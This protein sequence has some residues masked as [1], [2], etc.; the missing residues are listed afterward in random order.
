MRLFLPLLFFVAA[1][2]ALAQAPVVDTAGTGRLID[3][4]MNHSEVMQNLQHLSDV[5]GPRLSGSPAMRR[6][7][8]WSAERVRGD[9]LTAALEPYQF[10]VTWERGPA[11]LRLTAPFTRQVTA[12]SWAWTEGT[13]GKTLSG[14]VVMT[15]LSTPESLA[16]YK[17]KVK[18]A[19]VLPR[20]PFPIWNPDGPPMTAADSADL[21]AQ[22]KLRQS[23]FA[24]PSA[25]AVAA[26]RQFQI[27]LP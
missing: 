1:G 26:R 17:D 21:Q 23:P 9:G 15:D 19:W 6:A 22:I 14:P 7:N 16:V 13:G 12:H 10:G 11:T 5:I 2:P 24:D 27:D 4:A 3:Q 25:A 18:G 8:E 20:A